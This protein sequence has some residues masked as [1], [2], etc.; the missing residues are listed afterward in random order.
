[1][2][3]THWSS[4]L[5]TLSGT[6][7]NSTVPIGDIVTEYEGSAVVSVVVSVVVASVVVGVAVVSVT[8]VPVAASDPPSP[9]Q[10]ANSPPPRSAPPYLIASRRVGTS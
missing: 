8:V 10:P 9:L 5:T 7:S 3:S 2:W 6:D 4:K 1:M